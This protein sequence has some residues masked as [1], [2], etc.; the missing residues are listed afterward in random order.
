MHV[1]LLQGAGKGF[2]GGYDLVEYAETPGEMPG[3]QD[4]PW[5]QSEDQRATLEQIFVNLTCG[6]HPHNDSKAEAA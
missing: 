6:E 3:N 5:K 2:C 4:M 1:I